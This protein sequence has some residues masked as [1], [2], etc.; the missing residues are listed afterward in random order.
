M[1]STT[2]PLA[3]GTIEGVNAALVAFAKAGIPPTATV[4]VKRK[5]GGGLTALTATWDPAEQ[6]EAS[7]E[8][9]APPTA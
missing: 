4:S 9:E 7:D 2:Q 8:P 5:R 3:D 6:T 1:L